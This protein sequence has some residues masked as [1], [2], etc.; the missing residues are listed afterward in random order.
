MLPLREVAGNR[1]VASKWFVFVISTTREYV[2][3]P[4]VDGALIIGDVV[5]TSPSILCRPVSLAMLVQVSAC[6]FFGM[7]RVFPKAFAGETWNVDEVLVD[8]LD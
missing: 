5:A 8:G 6:R 2:T 1:P 4:V 7:C 3:P